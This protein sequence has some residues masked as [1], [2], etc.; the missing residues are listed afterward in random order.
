MV[1]RFGAGTVQFAAERDQIA[2]IVQQW[3]VRLAS[4]SWFMKC[5]NQAIARAANIEDGCTGHCWEARFASQ[6]LLSEQA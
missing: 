3:R 1:Q 2:R 5:I 4:V 6:A